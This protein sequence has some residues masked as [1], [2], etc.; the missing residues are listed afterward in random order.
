M[1]LKAGTLRRQPL[2]GRSSAS[3]PWKAPRRSRVSW[4]LAP[5]RRLS[6]S[7]DVSHGLLEEAIEEGSRRQAAEREAVGRRKEAQ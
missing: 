6:R 3:P 7:S 4:L 5:P 2:L 1:T